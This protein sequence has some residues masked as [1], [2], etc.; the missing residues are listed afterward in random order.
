VRS[1]LVRFSV[2]S[3]LEQQRTVP[4]LLEWREAE[5][6]YPLEDT[7]ASVCVI[8]VTTRTARLISHHLRLLRVSVIKL[9]AVLVS[10]APRLNVDTSQLPSALLGSTD[11]GA[12]TAVC[13]GQ[14]WYSTW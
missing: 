12:R 2:F 8:P 13:M 6:P 14:S 3:C 4:K 5:P 11:S 10:S 9:D 1:N 7:I